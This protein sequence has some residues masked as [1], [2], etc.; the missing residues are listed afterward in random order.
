MEGEEV[1]KDYQQ[2]DKSEIIVGLDGDDLGLVRTDTMSLPDSNRICAVAEYGIPSTCQ[3]DVLE[4]VSELKLMI[5]IISA[6]Q[7]GLSERIRA[8]ESG[9]THKSLD[10]P[11]NEKDED[12]KEMGKLGGERHGA[13]Q[14]TITA[15]AVNPQVAYFEELQGSKVY[16]RILSGSSGI[17]TGS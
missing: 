4:P 5:Q 16:R 1:G 13:A 2:T 7:N 17:F 9:Y 14:T 10:L 3:A 8:F 15:E 11:T 12:Q 6:N